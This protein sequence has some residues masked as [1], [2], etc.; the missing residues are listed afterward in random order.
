MPQNDQ[1]GRKKRRYDE[2]PESG[3]YGMSL[4]EARK[5]PAYWVDKVGFRALVTEMLA[6][7]KPE[8]LPNGPLTA[9]EKSERKKLGAN[10][11]EMGMAMLGSKPKKKAMPT[12]KPM[13]PSGKDDK[14]GKP[15]KPVKPGISGAAKKKAISGALKNMKDSK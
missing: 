10:Q 7:G 4:S 12:P 6:K 3:M 1:Y 5:N 8:Y 13:P 15:G 11:K 2:T 14:G 9:A